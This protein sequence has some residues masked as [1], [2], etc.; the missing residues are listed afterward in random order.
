V[1]DVLNVTVGVQFPPPVLL[2]QIWKLPADER[3][4]VAVVVGVNVQVDRL[5][6]GPLLPA[7]RAPRVTV[8]VLLLLLHT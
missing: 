3:S 4:L 6:V 7:V 1:P 2:S 8:S 5:R